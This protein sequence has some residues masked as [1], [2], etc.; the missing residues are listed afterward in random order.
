[1]F[2]VMPVKFSGEPCRAS[3]MLRERELAFSWYLAQ[4]RLYSIPA[5]DILLLGVFKKMQR[6]SWIF[7]F[8]LVAGWSDI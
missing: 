4:L 3:Y 2:L 5:G 7:I 1:M 8:W 6:S